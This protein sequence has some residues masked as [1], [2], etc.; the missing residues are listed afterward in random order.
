MRLQELDAKRQQPVVL[1]VLRQEYPPP[2]AIARFK[3]EYDLTRRF[4]APGII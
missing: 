2:E 3:L 4:Q 1:K